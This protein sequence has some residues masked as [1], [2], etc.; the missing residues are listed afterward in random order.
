[1]LGLIDNV[2][3]ALVVILIITIAMKFS[4]AVTDME[5]YYLGNRSL[6]WALTVG[7]L[8]ATWYG[9][10]GTLGCVEYFAIYGLSIWGGWS[11]PAHLS[12]M[13]LA[14]WVGPKAR[15]RTD[16]TIADLLK[17]TYG[18]PVAIVGAVLMVIYCLQFGN[19]TTAGFV[20]KIAWGAPYLLTGAIV[21]GLVIFIAVVAG[22][23]GVAVT[24]MLLF[25]C[26]G[27]SVAIVVPLA[28]GDVGGWSGVV[29]AVGGADSDL[30]KPFLGIGPAQILMF[31][32]LSLGVY[33]DP[34]FYQRFSASD[35]PATGRRSLLW[36]LIIWAIFDIVLAGTGMLV[37]V[38][39]PDLPP[40]EGY[41]TMVLSIMPPGVRALFVVA[42]VGSAISAL[43]GYFLAGG[44]TFAYDIIGNLKKNYTDKGMLLL[45]R[46]SVAGMA[47]IGLLFAFQFKTAMDAYVLVSGAWMAAGFVPVVGAL[48]FKGKMTPTGGMASMLVG[49]GVYLIF[50]IWPIAAISYPLVVAFP[51]SIVAWVLGNRIGKSVQVPDVLQ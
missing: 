21:I 6:P 44:T 28:W 48:M 25:W 5:S 36:C 43:D 13:P 39:Y 26:L 42:L 19:I 10:V 4:K 34:S 33:A 50:S 31:I 16:L 20:G 38:M 14:L 29:T 9:G 22:L 41:V 49:G 15:V 8:V 47:I 32:I 24:D 17:K 35:S 7:A 40:G 45:T 11:L 3:I 27:F 46:I 18:K 30:L 1:M 51:A 23:M 12:R 2:V 37:L